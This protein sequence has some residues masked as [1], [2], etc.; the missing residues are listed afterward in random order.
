MSL[1]DKLA[2][3]SWLILQILVFPVII[4]LI[5][6]KAILRLARSNNCLVLALVTLGIYSINLFPH[7]AVVIWLLKLIN[8]D[9]ALLLATSILL[10]FTHMIA[11]VY[12]ENKIIG[13]SLLISIGSLLASVALN[14][15]L[16]KFNL[17]T[18]IISSALI[19][20]AVTGIVVACYNL[21]VIF[22]PEKDLNLTTNDKKVIELNLRSALG[23]RAEDCKDKLAPKTLQFI[24]R[25]ICSQKKYEQALKYTE[26]ILVRQINRELSQYV[27]NGRVTKTEEERERAIYFLYSILIQVMISKEIKLEDGTIV[28]KVALTPKW[29]GWVDSP[30]FALE[31]SNSEDKT[32]KV[33]FSGTSV[34]PAPCPGVVWTHLAD[35]TPSLN[36][37][38]P[39][40]TV[41]NGKIGEILGNNLYKNYNKTLIGMSLGGCIARLTN[42][43]FSNSIDK[44]VTFSC[45]G[46]LSLTTASKYYFSLAFIWLISLIF[47]NKF[48]YG[49]DLISGTISLLKSPVLGL[50]YGNLIAIS[51]F[52]ILSISSYLRGIYKENNLQLTKENETHYR[53]IG[54]IIPFI[55]S[56]PEKAKIFVAQTISHESCAHISFP[57]N[58]SPLKDLC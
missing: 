56:F 18:A 3:P 44:V 21:Y 41:C 26:N 4:F 1:L 57:K 35:F 14:T 20:S 50:Y 54:D 5:T 19:L 12:H 39:L 51:L 47:L 33:V 48:L 34:L 53:N 8:F 28:R 24:F 30:Y 10:I 7:T 42:K 32:L 55:G 6:L 38:T 46:E 11:L 40:M 36:I 43:E 45:P 25:S 22:R 16:P 37:G 49:G 58:I 31:V 2:T 9:P 29:L 52:S 27:K 15:W 13:N 23:M 17:I